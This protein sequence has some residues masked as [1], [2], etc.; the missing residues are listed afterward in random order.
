MAAIYRPRHQRQ[1]VAS[2]KNGSKNCTAYSAAMFVDAVTLG[3]SKVT[4]KQV[5]AWSSEPVPDPGSPGLNIPQV[6]AVLS[7]LGVVLDDRTG[8]PWAAVEAALDQDRRVV[9]QISYLELGAARCQHGD[10]G[11]AMLLQARRK[12]AGGIPGFEILANDP[13]C[14]T[15]KW[16]DDTA[17]H[18][19]ME[20]F[21]DETHLPGPGL[22]WATG[23]VV[24]RPA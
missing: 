9:A 1:L 14:S 6:V 3:G 2:D 24:P 20:K 15:A 12:R 10:F 5:R 16:Y 13:L 11:H 21:G 22:R 7:R 18:R 17:I 23:R 19:A 8:Q 4:G